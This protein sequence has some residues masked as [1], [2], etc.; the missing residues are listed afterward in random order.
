MPGTKHVRSVKYANNLRHIYRIAND[1]RYDD[2]KIKYTKIY[3]PARCYTGN[4]IVLVVV[5]YMYKYT[6][7]IGL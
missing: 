3:V 6:K 1:I 2:C 5:R 4:V 7:F